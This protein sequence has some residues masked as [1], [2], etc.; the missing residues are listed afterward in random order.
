MEPISTAQLIDA[1]GWRYATKKFDSARRIPTATWEAL[2]QSLVLTPSSYG[3]Q[4]WRFVVVTDPTRKRELVP[5]SW[6]QTQSA[7]CSHHVVFA[8]RTVL[9]EADVDRY[10]ARVSE[11]RQIPVASQVG[12][13]GMMIGDVVK[14]PRSAQVFEWAARQAYIALG[15]FMG[16]AAVLGIDTC[17]MEGIVP[18]QYDRILGLEGTG[19][20]TVV[21]C[22]AGYRAVD[23]KYSRLPKVRFPADEVIIRL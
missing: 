10:L 11:V 9:E 15:Q 20:S 18:A 23:D 3:L 8:V 19:Y 22:A 5:H 21:A 1:L 6:N 12:Y 16:S 14:G 13:R 2:E 4:P 7:D 17:P